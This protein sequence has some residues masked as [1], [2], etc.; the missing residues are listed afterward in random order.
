MAVLGNRSLVPGALDKLLLIGQFA[1]GKRLLYELLHNVQV[2]S[3]GLSSIS[4]FFEVQ[5]ELAAVLAGTDHSSV[6]ELNDF[7]KGVDKIAA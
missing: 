1:P 7:K 4:K 5:M 6:Q 3:V 2:T